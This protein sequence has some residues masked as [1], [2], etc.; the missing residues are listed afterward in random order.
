MRSLFAWSGVAPRN[1]ERWSAEAMPQKP[2]TL[3]SPGLVVPLGEE[4]DGLGSG[5]SE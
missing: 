4:P 2:A 5:W 1:S 3:F